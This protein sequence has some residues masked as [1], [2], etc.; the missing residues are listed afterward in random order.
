MDYLIFSA[1]ILTS[2]VG[3]FFWLKRTGRA[4]KTP[5]RLWLAT[6][7]LLTLGGLYTESAGRSASRD[8]QG[9]VEGFPPTYAVEVERLGHA[10]LPNNASQDTPIYQAIVDAE[11]R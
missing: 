6:A 4:E 7:G 2:Y 10:Q 8:V 1:V 3:L 9:M 5:W 11:I